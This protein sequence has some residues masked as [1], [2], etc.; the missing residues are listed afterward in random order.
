MEERESRDPVT[1]VVCGEDL[2]SDDS[3][4]LALSA[5]T[6]VCPECA[7]KYGGVY[8]S[9]RERWSVPP[10]FPSSVHDRLAEEAR[11]ED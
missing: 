1:C 8:D 10:S 9:E 11:Y 4:A 7:R 5:L 3:G 2:G 6:V